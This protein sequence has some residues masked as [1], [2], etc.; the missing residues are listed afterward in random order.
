MTVADPHIDRY[1]LSDKIV[2]IVF[3][4]IEEVTV[5]TELNSKHD[6]VTLF[7]II[8]MMDSD[9]KSRL[10]P[11][12]RHEQPRSYGGQAQAQA[13]RD[14][15]DNYAYDNTSFTVE[16]DRIGPSEIEGRS[17]TSRLQSCTS[18][19]RNIRSVLLLYNS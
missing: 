1:Q 6:C 7:D 5:I 4:P 13:F 19:V 2:C 3:I 18:I 11:N 15:E 9:E 8:L 17:Q 16:Y 12:E 10:V 14:E